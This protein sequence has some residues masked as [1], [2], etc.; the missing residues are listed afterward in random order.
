LSATGGLISAEDIKAA[1]DYK[2]QAETAKTALMASLSRGGQVQH[3][4][5]ALSW[6]NEGLKEMNKET[7]KIGKAWTF[8]GAIGAALMGPFVD[9]TG[10]R[11]RNAGFGEGTKGSKELEAFI[12]QRREAGILPQKLSA[13]LGG[14]MAQRS[15]D[16]YY[17]VGGYLT[18]SQTMGAGAGSNPV[19]EIAMDFKEM[20]G[21]V[22]QLRP[23]DMPRTET[24]IEG[25]R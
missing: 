20:L 25:I 21:L 16:A 23:E 18:P 19:N 8:A 9:D 3:W 11:M 24:N 7:S 12:K 14:Q 13:P 2:D 17:A 22:R 10:R 1:E 5:E 4:G 6:Y 15:A